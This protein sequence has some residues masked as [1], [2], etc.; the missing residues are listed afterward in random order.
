MAEIDASRQDIELAT[1]H[2]EYAKKLG[3]DP[4]QSP[5]DSLANVLHF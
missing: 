5:Y 1:Q 2:E 3:Y 4:S